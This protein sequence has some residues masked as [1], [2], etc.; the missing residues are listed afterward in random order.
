M[1]K[2]EDMVFQEDIVFQEPL[3][4]GLPHRSCHGTQPLLRFAAEIQ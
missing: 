3:G 1:G 2:E 4:A